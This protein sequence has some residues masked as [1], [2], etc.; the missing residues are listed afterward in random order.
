[1]T[2]DLPINQAR[3]EQVLSALQRQGTRCKVEE[4]AGFCPELTK[5]EV[6]LVIDYLTKTGQVCLTLDANRTY[7]V[8]A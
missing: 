7:W 8:K 6:F 5:D 2:M 4:V 3:I 1:M